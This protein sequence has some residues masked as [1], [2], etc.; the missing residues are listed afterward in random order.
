MVFILGCRNCAAVWHLGRGDVVLDAIGAMRHVL[1][2][3][4]ARGCGAL[5]E[6]KSLSANEAFLI[7]IAGVVDLNQACRRFA[8][9]LAD[10]ARIRAFVNA[11]P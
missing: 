3:C 1:G 4:R 9:E 11:S 2:V 10:D 6:S 7:T 5:L 8:E